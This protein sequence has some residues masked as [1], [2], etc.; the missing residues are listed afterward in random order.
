MKWDENS[1]HVTLGQR[2]REHV[3]EKTHWTYLEEAWRGMASLGTPTLATPQLLS[4]QHEIQGLKQHASRP[5]KPPL[6]WQ[7]PKKNKNGKAD[8]HQAFHWQNDNQKT[9]ELEADLGAVGQVASDSFKSIIRIQNRKNNKYIYICIRVLDGFGQNSFIR[10]RPF[11][12]NKQFTL[13]NLR[14]L[15]VYLS[16]GPG[17]PTTP[18]MNIL[19]PPA[20]LRQR[21]T[22][23]FLIAF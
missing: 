10:E 2:R 11:F 1:M 22:D 9:Q 19:S 16:Q 13:R 20:K 8:L 5:A 17:W 15:H 4:P 18:L 3:L 6:E 7:P 21:I 14:E 23:H 12:A